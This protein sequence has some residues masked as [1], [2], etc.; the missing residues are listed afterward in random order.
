MR[1]S[2]TFRVAPAD[3][4]EQGHVNNVAYLRWIQEV[5]VAHWLHAVTAETIERYSW[6]VLRHEIDYRKAAFRD[7]EITAVTWV[8]EWTRV[9]CERFTE[10]RRDADL[11]VSGRTYWCMIDR[12]TSKPARISTDLIQRFA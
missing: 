10:I 9:R 6:V 1:F 5:A 11:L 12:Q 2:H 3:I 7:D 8:G 4:D